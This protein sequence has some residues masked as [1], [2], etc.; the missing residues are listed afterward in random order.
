MRKIKLLAL[1]IDGT[2][3]AD[4]GLPIAQRDRDAIFRARAAGVFITMATGRILDVALRWIDALEI[5]IPV[6]LCNGA[7]IRDKEKSWF[8][9]SIPLGET[10]AI[11]EAYH[12]SGQKRYL[13]SDNRIYCTKEDYHKPLFDKWQQGEE[14]VFPVVVSDTEEEMY[15]SMYTD[16]DKVLVWA[17][18]DAHAPALKQVAQEFAGEFNVVRGEER[19][20][21][22]N[23]MGVSKGSGLRKLTEL[24]GL[25]MDEVMAIGDGGNDTE[26]LRAAGV[27]VAMAN[28]MSEAIEA[29]DYVTS[30]VRDCGVAAAID[31]FIFGK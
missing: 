9:D 21:E 12:G 3:I 7:D 27:G 31:K 14:A 5:D 22:F 19:N 15:A 4:M 11:M 28:A 20:V 8:R 13:F 26:M 2:L 16:V 6:I 18:D 25:S 1:D 10:R 23:K 30:D 29:A 17:P 24:L